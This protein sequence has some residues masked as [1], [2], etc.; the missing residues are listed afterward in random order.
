M[1]CLGTRGSDGFGLGWQLG[2]LILQVFVQTIW[3]FG[4]MSI[5]LCLL[6][7]MKTRRRAAHISQEVCGNASRLYIETVWQ[8]WTGRKWQLLL[9]AKPAGRRVYVLFYSNQAQHS[10][11][12]QMDSDQDTYKDNLFCT[13]TKYQKIKNAFREYTCLVWA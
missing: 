3:S 9:A 4:W 7:Y 2:L 12:Q 8:L 13:L 5:H 1:W 10:E 6:Q 11:L